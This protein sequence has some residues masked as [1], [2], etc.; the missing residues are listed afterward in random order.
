MLRKWKFMDIVR[1]ISL[2]DISTYPFT[3]NISH[4]KKYLPKDL[5]DKVVKVGRYTFGDAIV[6]LNDCIM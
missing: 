4:R 1:Y 2:S 5:L 3:Y 6:A